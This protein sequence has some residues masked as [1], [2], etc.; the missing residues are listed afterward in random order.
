MEHRYAGDLIKENHAMI[1]F[2]ASTF[3][4][5]SVVFLLRRS[6]KG[7]CMSRMPISTKKRRKFVYLERMLAC[8]IKTYQHDDNLHE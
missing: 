5:Q 1:E 3:M 4:S 7:S 2:D 8:H 6:F